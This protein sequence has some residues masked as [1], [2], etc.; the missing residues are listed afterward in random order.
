MPHCSSA[1]LQ[2]WHYRTRQDN[3]VEIS[4]KMVVLAEQLRM[5]VHKIEHL[6][7]HFSKFIVS[8]FIVRYSYTQIRNIKEFKPSLSLKPSSFVIGAPPFHIT[9]S[10]LDFLLVISI[11]LISP[12]IA[13]SLLPKPIIRA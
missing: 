8:P 11:N 5:Y 13:W 4:E 1:S 10:I 12:L 2:V 9:S 7:A 3:K 6:V